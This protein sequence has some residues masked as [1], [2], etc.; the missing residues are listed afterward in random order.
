MATAIESELLTVAEA[1]ALLKVSKVT[2]S[3]WLKQGWLPGYRVGPRA[4]RIRRADV[5]GLVEPVSGP[6][7]MP[8]NEEPSASASAPAWTWE[9]IPIDHELIASLRP[10]TEERRQALREA[11]ERADE[12]R[13][14]M[15]ERRGGGSSPIRRRRSEMRV[16]SCR[17]GLIDGE[18][19]R[20]C[21]GRRQRC[22]EMAVPGGVFRPS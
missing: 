14:R 7:D 22:G 18:S 3:R 15:R 5:A 2:I 12:L 21:A 19:L 4:V 16:K 11:I 9:S 20:R 6:A 1:A 17:R 13:Q 8:P 10:M